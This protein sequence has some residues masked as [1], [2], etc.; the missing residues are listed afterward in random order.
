[1]THTETAAATRDALARL[2]LPPQEVLDMVQSALALDCLSDDS[3]HWLRRMQLEQRRQQ[4]S[5]AGE[6]EANGIS[7]CERTLSAHSVQEI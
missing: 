5:P 4:K 1:M 2:W 3:R 7:P 6:G